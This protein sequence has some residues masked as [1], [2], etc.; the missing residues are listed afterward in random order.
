MSQLSISNKMPDKYFRLF[1]NLDLASKKKLVNKLT[2]SIKVESETKANL[3]NMS[4]SW[5]DDRN[6]NEIVEDIRKSSVNIS[7]FNRINKLKI[8][9]WV[10]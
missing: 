6:A 5:I 4:D 2:N 3:K 1:R 7:E 10:N 8:E 9:I